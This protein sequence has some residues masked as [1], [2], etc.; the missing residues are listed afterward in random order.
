MKSNQFC[1]KPSDQK[2]CSGRT[3]GVYVSTLERTKYWGETPCF[4]NAL[5]ELC[6]GIVPMIGVCNYSRLCTFTPILHTCN[7][8]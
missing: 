5:C 2:R 3:K 6:V 8:M 7:S 1:K 4:E